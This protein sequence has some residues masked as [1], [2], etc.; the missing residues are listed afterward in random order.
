[1][2]DYLIPEDFNLL[3]DFLLGWIEVALS[4]VKLKITWSIASTLT[5]VFVFDEQNCHRK[6]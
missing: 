2:T 4:V 5:R 1:M 6:T 3:K